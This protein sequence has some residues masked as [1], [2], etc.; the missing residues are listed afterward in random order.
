LYTIKQIL[1]SINKKNRGSLEDRLGPKTVNRKRP[2]RAKEGIVNLY[3]YRNALNYRVID[4]LVAPYIYYIIENGFMVLYLSP[5]YTSK[6]ILS[7][8]LSRP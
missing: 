6:Y 2:I 5:I 3:K 1:F 7:K 8:V 4:I